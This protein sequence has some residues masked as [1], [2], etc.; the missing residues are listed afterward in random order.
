MGNAGQVC[1]PKVQ[2]LAAGFKALLQSAGG[3]R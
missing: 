3:M 1:E 2:A